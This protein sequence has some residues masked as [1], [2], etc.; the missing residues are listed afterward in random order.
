MAP[1]TPAQNKFILHWGEM[2]TKWGIN[3][4]VAQVHA[5]LFVTEDPLNAEQIAQTLSVARSNVST[6]LRELQSWGLVR[7]EHRLGDRKDHYATFEDVWEM[8]RVVAAQR[9][10]REIDPT[11]EILRQCVAES[12]A[13]KTHDPYTH[14]RLSEML[15]FIESMTSWCDH[16]LRLPAWALQKLVKM[17]PRLGKIVGLTN[18]RP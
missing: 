10:A 8:Y 16:A 9:K 2:G 5:L 17:G 6:S 18:P 11:I 3:R 7:I 1:L 15:R 14:K 13:K 12:S 4:T